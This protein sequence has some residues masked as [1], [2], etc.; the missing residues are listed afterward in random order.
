MISARVKP[1]RAPELLS[2]LL[3]G[4][5]GAGFPY[6]DLGRVLLEGR[7]DATGTIRWVEVCYCREY[8]GVAMEEEL[9]YFEEYLTDMTIADARNPRGCKG[10]PEC[11][12]CSCTR[13]PGPAG[14][15]AFL[16]HL[17]G[18]ARGRSPAV[19]GSGRGPRWLGWRSRVSSAEAVRNA[20][21]DVAEPRS[22]ERS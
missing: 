7:V 2:S 19:Q 18:L 6:G 13:S 16:P 9:P 1:D 12:D 3:D 14:G 17:I 4:S 10:Y 21:S 22:R 5:F 20:A 11:G 15:E 8:Y